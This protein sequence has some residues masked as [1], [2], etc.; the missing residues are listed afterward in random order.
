MKTDKAV[1]HLLESMRR[2]AA[3]TE[4][5]E[6][7][8][9]FE[10]KIAEIEA[11]QGCQPSGDVEFPFPPKRLPKPGPPPKP[12]ALGGVRQMSEAHAS[13]LFL[14]GAFGS[15]GVAGLTQG[16]TPGAL[17]F[18]GVGLAAGAVTLVLHSLRR[19]D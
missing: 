13:F 17:M 6:E 12:I 3:E 9:A 7:R 16:V 19:I 2:L 4:H 5:P 10:R 1:D 11:G 15:V 8:E 18:L 14:A